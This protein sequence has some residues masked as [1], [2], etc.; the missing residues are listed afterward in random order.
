[1]KTGRYL[2]MQTTVSDRVVTGSCRFDLTASE[3][4]ELMADAELVH[5]IAPDHINLAEIWLEKKP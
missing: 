2:F 3:A 5:E 1:M 4:N